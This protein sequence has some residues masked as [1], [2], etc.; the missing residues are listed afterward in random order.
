M[1]LHASTSAVQKVNAFKSSLLLLTQISYRDR[2]LQSLRVAPSH[3]SANEIVSSRRLG[4]LH[5]GSRILRATHRFISK[6]YRRSIQIHLNLI[7]TS[8]AE[9]LR[10]FEVNT[11]EES[12]CCIEAF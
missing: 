9:E 2:G 10:L 7:P 12:S 4:R 1:I 11:I 5:V 8:S 6:P 3:E